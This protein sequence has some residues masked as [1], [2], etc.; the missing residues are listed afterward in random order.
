M[1]ATFVLYLNIKLSEMLFNSALNCMNYNYI[2]LCVCVCVCVGV[3]VCVCLCVSECV[4][5]LDCVYKCWAH[6]YVIRPFIKM[7]D[8]YCENSL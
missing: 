8:K 6:T 5:V 1:G 4:R 2:Y 3:C 7:Q